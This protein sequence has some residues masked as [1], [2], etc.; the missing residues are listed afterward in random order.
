MPL[1]PMRRD[2]NSARYTVDQNS[3]RDK[4]EFSLGVGHL[5]S[6][7]SNA[8]QKLK[9]RKFYR[10]VTVVV[11]H[12]LER[13]I[14]IAT[15]QAGNNPRKKENHKWAYLDSY[16][17]VRQQSLKEGKW[18]IDLLVIALS[19]WQ[20]GNIVRFVVGKSKWLFGTSWDRMV[21]VHIA[22]YLD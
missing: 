10:P 1:F 13:L 17:P 21:S 22:I 20:F 19:L 2:K 7:L 16:L 8:T 12:I 4:I 11:I 9:K 5:E 6:Y 14:W 15:Y 18:Q 3:N